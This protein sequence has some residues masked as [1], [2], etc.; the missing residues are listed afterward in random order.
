MCPD[1]LCCRK[2][3]GIGKYPQETAGKWGYL[4][5]CDIPMVLYY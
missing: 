1:P 5:K 3:N 4:G 2:V